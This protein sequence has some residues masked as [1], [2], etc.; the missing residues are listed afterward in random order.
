MTTASRPFRRPEPAQMIDVRCSATLPS[1]CPTEGRCQLFAGHDGPHA[2]MFGRRGERLVRTW[3]GKD[4]ASL[5]DSAALQ[6]PWMFGYP[7]PAWYEADTTSE[8]TG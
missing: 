1:R 2:L 3:K 4:P 5:V 8:L 6:R 7:V